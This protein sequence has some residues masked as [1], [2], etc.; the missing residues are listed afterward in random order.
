MKDRRAGG[1]IREVG[2]AD[3]RQTILNVLGTLREI[4]FEPVQA[5]ALIYQV[6]LVYSEVKAKDI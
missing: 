3:L 2:E 6:M 1:T 5:C 4:R